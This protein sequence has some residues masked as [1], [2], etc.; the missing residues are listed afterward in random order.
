MP[1]KPNSTLSGKK[2]TYT[3][4]VVTA[5]LTVLVAY[6]FE[7]SEVHWILATTGNMHPLLVHLPIGILLALGAMELA[8]YLNPNL[9]LKPACGFLLWLAVLT[10]IPTVIAGTLLAAAGDYG[11]DTLTLHK[12]MGYATTIMSIWLLVIRKGH[13]HNPS[14][15]FT[16][17]RGAMLLNVAILG[18]TGHF[19]GSLTHGSS[20]L[21]EHVPEEVKTFFGADPYSMDGLATM[22]TAL[23]N[24]TLE[25]YQFDA[26]IQPITTNYC[27]GC[28]GEEEQKGGLRLDNIDPDLV[29]GHDAETWRVML[30]MV[31]SGE[32]PPKE[33]KQLSDEERRLLVDWITAS[34][35]QAVAIKKSE[36]KPVI[37]RLTRQQYTNSLQ[38]LLQLPL[39]FGDVLPE[40]AKSEMGFSN[41]GQVLQIS[42]LHAE[43]YQD[44]ARAALDKAIAPA[45]KP[46]VTRYRITFGK[47]IGQGKPAGQIGG[48]QSVP[49]SPDDFIVEILDENGHPKVGL[50]SAAKAQLTEI[51][52]NI[53]VG[54]RGSSPDRFQVVEE[55]MVL[56]SA[57]PH[58]EVTPKSWQGPSPNLK[59]LFRNHFPETGDFQLRV[60]ASK[61]NQLY[62]QRFGFLALRDEVPAED[63]PGKIVLHASEAGQL[64]N[65]VPKGKKLVP[66]N[67]TGWSR[68]MLTFEAPQTGYYQID[69]VHPYVGAEG[70]PSLE[71]MVDKVKLQERLHMDEALKDAPSITTPVTLAYLKE[72]KHQLQIGGAFFTGFERIIVTPYPD[73]HPL[74]QE[75]RE[76]AAKSRAK[77]DNDLPII[78]TFAGS[79]T[80]DGMDYQTFDTYQNVTAP[81]GEWETYTFHGRLENLPIPEIDTVET[82]ILA[83]IMVLGLWNDFL[84]KDNSESGPPLLI[85][86]L[87][88]EAP[89][90]PTWPPKSH[91]AIFPD[92]AQKEERATQAGTGFFDWFSKKTAET[93]EDDPEAYTRKVLTDFMEKAYRRPLKE[94][95]LQPYMDFWQGIRHQYPRYEEGVKEV[96]IAVLCSPKF[97]YLAEPERDTSE[98]EKEFFLA[99]RLSYFLWNAPPDAELLELAADEDLHDE[100]ELKEQV[101]RMVQDEKIWEMVRRFSYE[102]LRLDR[103]EAMS[104][105]VNE[106]PDFTRFVKQ[107]MLEETYHFV[108]HVLQT[109][110]SIFKLINSDFAMLNQ[111]LAEFYG[112]DSVKG[113]HFRPVPLGRNM[114][115]GGLLSQGAFLSGHSDG[116][117]AH[118]IKRAVWLKEK[119]LGEHPPPPPPNVPE[120]DPETPGFEKLTLKEQLLIHRDKPACMDCHRKIDPYG[121]V[122][123][124]YDAVGRYQTIAK[125]KPID[126]MVELPD[127]QTVEGIDEIKSYILELKSDDFTRSLV[128]HLFAYA[129]GR[130]A[131]FVDEGEI[132]RIVHEVREDGYRFQSVIENIVISPSFRG[133]F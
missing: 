36:Q 7:G 82:E 79:R 51:K 24:E 32:M 74:A 56:Y 80:D 86:E 63:L 113:A 67:V 118:A 71:L 48:F 120:L 75:L 108:H 58:K 44:I 1:S 129:L 54:M 85:K 18:V 55:G 17:Y 27:V 96:L 119:I 61:G 103:H 40:D 81:M 131:T 107:D 115:R 87:E 31:N 21:T 112:I 133:D 8:D 104:T 132:E 43:Y 46:E 100:D 45:E 95:E 35:Q 116:T 59:L 77:F 125:E 6:P 72:G 70:M 41:N 89:Y 68:A 126:A 37:R 101:Q 14:S 50:D 5:L 15:S 127:G 2:L 11:S 52:Q 117:Q 90:Y 99:S 111:N 106:Y 92:A 65:M 84:V 93:P 12:W 26:H 33:K 20:F 123:E 19:G 130:D 16:P 114:P 9:Q 83:N 10:S 22:E 34:I 128:K 62:T 49:I 109:D 30:D 38:Q 88:F 121:I 78:R 25:K 28:H 42:P 105:N 60:K 66:Q 110:K 124:N 47:G 57:V 53:G 102:W 13:E 98:E 97:L 122:F 73:S 3:A 91:L 23:M 39:N 29:H 4:A 64:V 76:E 69:Y 94:G